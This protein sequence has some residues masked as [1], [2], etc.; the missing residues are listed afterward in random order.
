M[1]PVLTPQLDPASPRGW[2]ARWF[3]IIFHHD[4]PPARNFDLWLVVAIIASVIVVMLDSDPWLH[5][6]YA[7]I[8]YVL[9]WGFTLLFTAEY[10]VRLMVLRRPLRYVFSLWGLI[11]LLSILPTYLSLLLPGSQALLVVRV[12]RVL[13]LFRVLKMTQY[14]EESGVLLGALWRSRRKIFLFVSLLL[15]IAVVFGGVMFV[16]EGPEHGFATIPTGM[17]WAITTMATVGYGDLVPQTPAG[18]MVASALVLIGY[19]IIAVPTGIY[20]AE[21]VNSIRDGAASDA[22]DRRRCRD[23]Q[24][25]GHSP[26]AVFCR[27]C[28]SD[29]PAADG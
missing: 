17:Y 4:T 8:L 15:T 11:D 13:R 28:G 2:R 1:R 14:V 24:L 29:L 20:T 26:D 18:R 19:S 21:L 23:C 5:V 16:L 27:G 25:G 22:R 9:E 3:H 12:L 7:R 10:A 6:D